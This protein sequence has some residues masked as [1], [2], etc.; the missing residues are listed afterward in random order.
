MKCIAVRKPQKGDE[1]T[2]ICG[3]GGYG[4]Y[5]TE[6]DGEA[7]KAAYEFYFKDDDYGLE[8][9]KIL[10]YMEAMRSE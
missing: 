2:A 9:S 4:V 10:W 8:G 7:F 5:G 1:R 3:Q 6:V